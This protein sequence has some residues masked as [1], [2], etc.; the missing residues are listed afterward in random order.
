MK[1]INVL[2]TLIAALGL[3][4]TSTAALAYPIMNIADFSCPDAR[5]VANYGSYLAGFGSEAIVGQYN[6]IYFQSDYWLGGI[7][8]SLVNYSNSAANYDS[9]TGIIS[10]SYTSTAETEKSFDLKYYVTNGKGGLIQYQS[11]TDISV[12]FPIGLH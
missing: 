9:T 12:G 6:E 2:S 10:C 8:D 4:I 3:A 1:K 5:V 7:P 11:N